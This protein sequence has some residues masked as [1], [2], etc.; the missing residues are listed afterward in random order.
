MHYA[1]RIYT[2][3]EDFF[4]TAFFSL[5][6]HGFSTMV[7]IAG[8]GVTP[9]GC[10]VPATSMVTSPAEV[11]NGSVPAVSTAPPGGTSSQRIWSRSPFGTWGWVEK[12]RDCKT[13]NVSLQQ[14]CYLTILQNSNI[15][16]GGFDCMHFTFAHYLTTPGDQW[17]GFGQLHR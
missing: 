17:Q 6:A 4:M 7:L 8:G 12:L 2:Y 13:N 3:S 10:E 11:V 16:P 5:R 9:A 1:K 14:L 15:I